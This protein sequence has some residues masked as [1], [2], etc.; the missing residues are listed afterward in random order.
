MLAPHGY[1]QDIAR[2][3]GSW[4]AWPNSIPAM[5]KYSM[6]RKRRGSAGAVVKLQY[7]DREQ[8]I[9]SIATALFENRGYERTS[10]KNIADEAGIETASLYYYFSSKE[11]LYVSV[12]ERSL[13]ILGDNVR[14]ATEGV[15]DPWEKLERAAI[16]HCETMLPRDVIQVA[17]HPRFPLGISEESLREL[18]RQ[19][20]EYELMMREII[21]GISLR[22]D[23]DRTLFINFFLSSLNYTGL[24]YKPG[25]RLTPA[26]IASGAVAIVRG[27][28][29]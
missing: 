3:W 19:R 10:L 27:C 2:P 11:D 16:A 18:K 17:I 9:L 25:G 23:V 6:N 26:E 29:A 7:D 22:K 4:P 8:Q 24:W 15:D 14:R 5:G 13:K 21:D 28:A 1:I 12:M 20:R